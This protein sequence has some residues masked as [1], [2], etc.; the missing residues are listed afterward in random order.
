MEIL[1]KEVIR[2]DHQDYEYIRIE[3]M[4]IHEY[5]HIIYVYINTYKI[6]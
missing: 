5:I 6:V 2:S 4:Y 1:K 3:Y